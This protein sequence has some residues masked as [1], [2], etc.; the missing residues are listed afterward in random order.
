METPGSSLVDI[1][2]EF[3]L[4]FRRTRE[5]ISLY[6]ADELSFE[7]VRGWVGD[8]ESSALFRLKERCHAIYRDDPHPGAP[9]APMEREALF[10]L[11]VGA[12]F[13]EAMRFRENVYQCEVYGPRV[14]RLSGRSEE[15]ADLIREFKRIV[16]GAAVRLD[17]AI[18]ELEALL[19][20]TRRQF[21]GL[22]QAR[23]HDGLVARFL[24]ENAG[25]V[26]LAFEGGVE[27]LFEQIHGDAASGY[28]LAARSYL[29]SGHFEACR[30]GGEREAWLRLGEYASAMVAYLRG[31][32][33]D[34]MEAL[35]AWIERAP[36]ADESGYAA[37]ALDAVCH[38]GRLTEGDQWKA[39]A[40]DAERLAERLQSLAA[41]AA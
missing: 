4:S 15:E 20:Q 22:L 36:A 18:H 5:I 12:L 7:D 11:T 31:D 26:V 35:A 3:L 28:A 2:R 38:V 8:D 40:A 13:H 19:E 1:A 37:L 33:R 9:E 41:P 23:P 21:R 10:D 24:I 30:R 27:T 29:D 16:A 6:R 25:Y 39:M 34:A 14:E 17:E 32:Y